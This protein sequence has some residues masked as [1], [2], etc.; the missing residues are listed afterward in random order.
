MKFPHW[1]LIVWLIL[2]A[3]IGAFEGLGIA[4]G[5]L[6]TL[7]AIIKATIPVWARAMIWGWLGWHFVI[8]P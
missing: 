7:T 6:A 1:N 2:L 5:K 4:N 3:A 8:K